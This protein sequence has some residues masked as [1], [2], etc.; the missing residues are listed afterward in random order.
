VG[1]GTL[2]AALIAVGVGCV[3]F[4]VLTSPRGVSPTLVRAG[5]AAFYFGIASLIAGVAI[6]ISRRRGTGR[7]E[8]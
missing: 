2:G 3:L 1:R 5:G 6:R 4:Y 7:P 8:R